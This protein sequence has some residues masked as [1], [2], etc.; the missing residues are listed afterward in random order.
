MTTFPLFEKPDDDQT[1]DHEFRIGLVMAGAISA[2]AYT[3]GVMDFMIEAIREW[4]KAKQTHPQNTPRHKVRF[5]ALAGASA[6]G[7]CAG[8][9][10]SALRQYQPG[11]KNLTPDT[12]ALNS[13]YRAWVVEVGID[14]MLTMGD[15]KDDQAPQSVLNVEGDQGLEGI[16]DRALNIPGGQTWPAWLKD[17]L[18]IFLCLTNLRGV[19]YSLHFTGGAGTLHGMSVHKDY[20]LF[21]LSPQGHAYDDALPLDFTQTGTVTAGWQ[22]LG[23]ACLATGAFPAAFKPRYLSRKAVEYDRRKIPVSKQEGSVEWR[24]IKPAWRQDFDSS[25]YDY[26]FWNVDGGTLNNEPMELARLAIADKTGRNERN[27]AKATRM[28]LMIDPFPNK[29]TF[30]DP[31]EKKGDLLSSLGG[32]VNAMKQQARFK[33]ED[34]LLFGN[35]EVASRFAIAPSRYAVENGRKVPSEMPLASGSLGAFGGMLSIGWRH[36]DYLLGRLNCQKFL[37]DWFAVEPTHRLIDTDTAQ[38]TSNGKARIIPLVSGYDRPE[39]AV[40]GLG[41]D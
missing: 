2:G 18:P 24:E 4:E 14:A 10:A 20:A 32:L 31:Y 39:A 34:V 36:H 6:G 40:L 21:A 11:V 7:M 41:G 25:H 17:P 35:T 28:V 29:D 23:E 5:D 19:P 13:F 15:L 33:E 9:F 26:G 38:F 3:A 27:P 16:R 8:I 30:E 12:G 37:M 1:Q 22:I